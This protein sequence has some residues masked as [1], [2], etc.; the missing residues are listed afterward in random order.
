MK[1]K[2]PYLSALILAF[3]YLNVPNL[4]AQNV[5]INSSG[6]SP[7]ASAM[8]DISSS[9]KGLLIPR[10]SLSG[11][12]DASTIS[13]PTHSLMIYNTNAAITGGVG[14]YYNSGTSGSPTWS[15]IGTL[16]GIDNGFLWTLSGNSG[17]GA[18]NFLGTTDAQDL[19]VKTNNTNRLKITSAGLTTIGDGTNQIKFGT[20][21]NWTLE[22][23]ATVWND[24]MVFPDATTRGG[25]NAPSWSIFKNNGSGSQGVF[26]YFFSDGSEQELYFTVQV[27]HNYK[28]GSSIYPHVHWT[29]TSGTPSGSN[30]VWGLEYSVVSFGGTFPNTSINTGSTT[31]AEVGSLSG[32]HQHII[33]SLGTIPGT[34][35]GISTILVCRLFR[36]TGDPADTF[37]NS[38]GLLSF[39]LHYEM[40]A[41]GSSTM[42]SK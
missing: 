16:S 11:L 20:D 14:Y 38:I 32:T 26:L 4:M 42:F 27:P 1:T 29:T 40:D 19:V 10:V 5:G 34:G 13:S 31:V 28:E 12:S 8:L 33:T 7:D 25:S 30:V 3:L 23:S 17:T 37:S 2:S 24:M 39:D 21:G 9:S 18:S 15:K 22:G 36:K 35:I 41:F 6:S